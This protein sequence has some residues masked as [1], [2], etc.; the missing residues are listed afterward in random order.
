MSSCAHL[1]NLWKAVGHLAW[2][3]TDR[4]YLTRIIKSAVRAKHIFGARTW[5][6]SQLNEL[7]ITSVAAGVIAILHTH[8]M[9]CH[10]FNVCRWL[11]WCHRRAR[12]RA[13]K[14]C[15]AVGRIHDSGNFLTL[16][17]LSARLID[18]TVTVCV[19]LRF[20]QDVMQMCF[21]YHR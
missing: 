3:K 5:L 10:S 16:E 9:L 15:L 4:V 2:L 14:F 8:S 11:D 1:Q 18:N 6:S 13:V 19:C 12:F 17:E 20:Q 21:N 7:L